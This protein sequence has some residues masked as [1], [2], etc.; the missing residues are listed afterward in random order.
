MIRGQSRH[1]FADAVKFQAKTR[2]VP[3][4]C[5]HFCAAVVRLCKLRWP[6]GSE[7]GVDADRSRTAHT[8]RVRVRPPG[9]ACDAGCADHGS[10]GAGPGCGAL[11]R[12]VV[13]ASDGAG[14]APT[15]CAS[16]GQERR[17]RRQGRGR[18]PARCVAGSTRSGRAGG[19][20]AHTRQRCA[21]AGAIDMVLGGSLHGVGPQ[22]RAG[23][24]DGRLCR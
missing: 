24:R 18:N 3:T 8:F 11:S 21:P 2:R 22:Y 1:G 6:C 7:D 10:D 4:F 19:V 9:R 13:P 5:K 23:R 15:Q 20:C 12:C 17:R 14:V 16:G